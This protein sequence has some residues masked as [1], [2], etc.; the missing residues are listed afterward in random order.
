MRTT[1]PATIKKGK[2]PL[3]PYNLFFR[4]KRIKIIQAS[5]SGISSRS[6]ILKLV[7]SVP[8]LE[9]RTTF[10]LE[11][12]LPQEKHALGR[13]AVRQEM[14]DKL[15][16]FEGKRAHRKTPG[17]MA[18]AD[19][20]RM[21]YDEWKLL[22]ESSKSIFVEL[23]EDGKKEYR[24][25][26]S[27][28]SDSIQSMVC[29]ND[30]FHHNL[31]DQEPET[32]NVVAMPSHN[33]GFASFSMPSLT[34]CPQDAIFD[35]SP[36]TSLQNELE[37]KAVNI[38]TPNTPSK[39]KLQLANFGSNPTFKSNPLYTSEAESY[40]SDEDEFCRFIDANMHLVD[41]VEHKSVFDL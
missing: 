29:H 21:M 41:D 6:S 15:L 32:Q 30:D 17:T 7:R 20:S 1:R 31:I 28:E 38:V 4:Y 27:S 3:T 5:S 12:M 19:M 34:D 37:C 11:L 18:F 2:R 14:R 39:P 25:Q 40:S 36:K 10:A 13:A 26:R 9:N 16:P 24:E 8:G 23:A 33:A 22:D 35:V